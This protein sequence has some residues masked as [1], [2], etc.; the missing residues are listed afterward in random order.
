[1]QPALPLFVAGPNS[2]LQTV[3]DALVD[4]LDFTGRWDEWLSLSQQAEARAVAAGDHTNAGWRAMHAGAVH[5]YRN[6]T[7]AVLACA[8]RAAA[9]WQT[10]QAGARERAAAIAAYREA[11]VLHCSV[12]AES[13]D[14]AIDLNAL[15][16]IEMFSGDFG[17]A[18]QDY[19]EA[20]R[21]A[22]AVSD[23]EMMAGLPGNLAGLALDRQDWPGAEVLAREA[24][25]LCETVGRQGLIASNCRRLARAL[26]RQGK[27]A[28]ALPYARRAVEIYTQL[29]HPDLESARVILGECES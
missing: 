7:D 3:C 5:E 6:Q 4:F 22:R 27:K 23:T 26:V 24:L 19:R 2:R 28:E 9:Y 15:A 16:N 17:A 10:A 12:S 1:M 13:K 14:V 29:G 25:A 21:I 11:L 8:D 20:L 18:E